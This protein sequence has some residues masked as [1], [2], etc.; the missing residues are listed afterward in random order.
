MVKKNK[1]R[2][3]LVVDNPMR[4]LPGLVLVASELAKRNTIPVLVPFNLCPKELYF[5]APDFVLLNYLRAT[6][7]NKRVDFID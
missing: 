1:Y 2:I 5:L 3:A 7:V 4:D 6:N